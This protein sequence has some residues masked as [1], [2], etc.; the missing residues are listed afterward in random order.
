[1]LRPH[2]HPK[3]ARTSIKRPTSQHYETLTRDLTGSNSSRCACVDGT[4]CGFTNGRFDG[5]VIH[6]IAFGRSRLN[7]SNSVRF[8]ATAENVALER[9]PRAG[10]RRGQYALSFHPRSSLKRRNPE[11]PSGTAAQTGRF[12]NNIASIFW[13]SQILMSVLRGLATPKPPTHTVTPRD[14]DQFWATISC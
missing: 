8:P 3:S 10:T 2:R 5:H 12:Q 1:M 11:A 4:C 9:L 6:L 7:G 13:R 14:L